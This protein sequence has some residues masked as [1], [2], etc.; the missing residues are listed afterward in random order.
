MESALKV[1]P[2]CEVVDLSGEQICRSNLL[3]E[4]SREQIV[5]HMGFVKSGY[6][7]TTLAIMIKI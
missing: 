7:L 1:R 2:L 3:C 6:I 5:L 4:H